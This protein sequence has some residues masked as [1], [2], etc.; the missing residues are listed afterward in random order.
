[1]HEIQELRVAVERG[2]QAPVGSG[3]RAK[4]TLLK[5]AYRLVAIEGHRHYWPWLVALVLL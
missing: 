3:P 1:L 5:E 4:N 2:L